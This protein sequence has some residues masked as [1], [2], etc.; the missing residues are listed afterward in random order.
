MRRRARDPAGTAESARRHVPAHVPDVRGPR[1]QAVFA[2]RD[3]L[4]IAE[5]GSRS[6]EGR[7]EGFGEGLLLLV[8][9]H[10]AYLRQILEEQQRERLVGE[11]AVAAV[12]DLVLD[13]RSG[14][15]G[16]GIGNLDDAQPQ[17]LHG[18]GVGV[19]QIEIEFGEVG[20]DVGRGPAP[21]DDVVN[22]GLLG[23]MLTQQIHHGRHRLDAVEGR[24]APIR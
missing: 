1:V 7:V 2:G 12:D 21:G 20:D 15:H 6:F 11:Q 19:A 10:A 22:P 23:H 18:E 14:S 17:T 8:V 24:A 9:L 4:L 5:L 13:A 16:G 3:G